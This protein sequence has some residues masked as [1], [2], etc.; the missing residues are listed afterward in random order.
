M[1]GEEYDAVVVGAGS[2]GCALAG[3][4]AQHRRVLLLEAGP[5]TWAPEILDVAS[6]APA[7][8]GH[9]A[10]WDHP[11]A[12]RPGHATTVPRGRVVGGSG[13]IN[14]AVWCRATPSDGWAHPGWT[15]ADMLARYI[16]AESDADLGD[17]PEHG[18]A[19]PVPVRR[20]AGPLRH[21]AAERFLAAAVTCGFPVEPDK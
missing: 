8:P 19:G 6:L 4:L 9:P 12:L 2:A 5:T 1:S 20:P 14:G 7:S 11:V 16:R 21:P 15:W 10:N 18:D 3:R 13:G 17:R